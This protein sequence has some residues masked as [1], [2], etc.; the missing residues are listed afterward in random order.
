MDDDLLLP[1]LID[2]ITALSLLQQW[3]PGG[4]VP[5]RLFLLDLGKRSKAQA[6]L[7]DVIQPVHEVITQLIA[8]D[9]GIQYNE[10]FNIKIAWEYGIVDDM[11]DFIRRSIYICSFNLVGTVTFT[12]WTG[13]RKI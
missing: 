3:F 10:S 7:L 9:P 8:S 4:D 2:D 13:M 5:L 11:P 6:M 12:H 1:A